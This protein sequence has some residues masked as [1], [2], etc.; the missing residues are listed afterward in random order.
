MK[1]PNKTPY[2]LPS[3]APSIPPRFLDPFPRKEAEV[4]I[5]KERIQ[6]PSDSSYRKFEGH[7]ES[8]FIMANMEQGWA[9]KLINPNKEKEIFARICWLLSDTGTYALRSTFDSIHPP[10]NLKDHLAQ[11]HIRAVLQR[12]QEQEILNDRQWKLLYPV[13]KKHVSSQ[14]YDSRTLIILLQS[15]CHLCPP[16]PNGWTSM[17]LS[18]DSSISA[19]IVRLQLLYQ[20]VAAKETISIEDYTTLWKQIREVLLRLGGPPIRVR[21]HRIEHEVVAADMQAHYITTLKESWGS[22][23]HR[24]ITTPNSTMS[25]G[26]RKSRKRRDNKSDTEGIPPE[27]KAVLMKTFKLFVDN[28]QA[29][30]IVDRLQQNQVI[31]F[32]D[33]QEIFAHSKNTERMQM[34]LDKILKSKLSYA[35]KA[36]CDSIKFKYKKMYENV[37]QIRKDTYK[38]GVRETV[39]VVGVCTDALT[40]SYANTY[41]KCS[42]FPWNETIVVNARDMYT[43]LDILDN[44]GRK[45]H[46]SEFLPSNSH[47]KGQ[48]IILEGS[49]GSGKTILLHVVAYLWATQRKY[50]KNHY[51][52][53]IHFNLQELDGKFEDAICRK[54]L[55]D[56]FRL[57]PAEFFSLLEA[58]SR[59]VVMLIDGY[60]G[61]LGHEELEDILLGERLRQ[62]T[63]IVAMNPEVVSNPG[64]TPDSRYFNL[65]FS[66]NNVTRFMKTCMYHFKFNPEHHER[67]FDSINDTSWK[68]YPNL[69]LPLT[70][71]LVFAIYQSSK[72]SNVLDISGTTSLLEAY[73]FA[74]ATQFCKRQK[75]DIIGLEF[76]EEVVRAIDQLS[77]F[78]YNNLMEDERMFTIQEITM[79]AQNAIILKLGAFL[80]L[81]PKSKWNLTCTLMH[82]FLAARYISDFVLDEM[83]SIIKDHRIV[84][85]SK[86]NYLVMLLCGLYRNDYDTKVIHSIFSEMAVQNVRLTRV[87]SHDSKA[88]QQDVRPPSG[89]IT[90]FL[91]SLQSLYE[92]KFRDDACTALAQS[93]PPRTVIRRD[94]LIPAK[95]LI[96]L[97]K[98]MLSE[99][100]RVTQIEIHLLPVF[101]YQS[102]LYLELAGE[103]SKSKILQQ[104]KIIW[105]SMEMMAKF[106]DTFMSSIESIKSI[107]LDDVSKKPVKQVSASTWATLQSACQNLTKAEE[108]SFLHSKVATVSYFVLQHLPN[109]LKMLS[110]SGCVLNMMCATE[111]SAKLE[112]ATAL[113]KLDISNTGLVGSEFV[114]VLQG[115]KLCNTIRHLKL[116]GAKLDRAGVLNLSECLKLTRTLE[117]LDLSNCELSTDMCK[118][119]ADAIVENRSLQKLVLKSTKVST[120]GRQ[121]I[122]Q[123]KQDQVQVIGLEDMTYAIYALNVS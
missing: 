112:H 100:S 102:D 109:S 10:L 26:T 54:L 122:S 8:E 16:Y 71:L 69:T 27:D 80:K 86:Y 1:G 31:K 85:Q 37:M 43:P 17:P 39:D 73:G 91:Q 75:L 93:F 118:K 36:L 18:T 98:I 9:S 48:R 77:S 57:N 44:D 45:I 101:L 83:I 3:V 29:E 97:P 123:P 117:I 64:F 49:S 81:T 74:M 61:G 13:K 114:A 92:T 52:L 89:K 47:G 99:S 42:P 68:L 25:K 14:Q 21:L 50:F 38:H 11:P 119:L 106:L 78:A 2:S 20:Q 34:I 46:L 65:G 41:A 107:I 88:S 60:D 58:N 23:K 35:F 55:P 51:P 6:K 76:P 95:A 87:Q 121:A 32:S 7:Y 110:F 96:A 104:L 115:L 120:E 40:S 67:L 24:T 56:S 82:D 90:D 33:R 116:C 12:L 15:I 63:V 22:G 4:H 53:L 66:R 113:E 5:A 70:S 30:D 94:G 59:D 62:A 19:D 72:K 111:V 79:D 108:F 84:K 105:H 28:V 103:I